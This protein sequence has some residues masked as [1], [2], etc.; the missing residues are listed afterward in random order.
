MKR[1]GS[2]VVFNSSANSIDAQ[3]PRLVAEDR[4]PS[5]GRDK[6]FVLN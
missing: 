6:T 4:R 2:N 1:N 3:S 5:G